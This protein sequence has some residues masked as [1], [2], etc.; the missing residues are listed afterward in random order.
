MS[1]NHKSQEALERRPAMWRQKEARRPLNLEDL[2]DTMRQTVQSSEGRRHKRRASRDYKLEG[3]ALTE[4]LGG[5]SMGGN[6]YTRE[7]SAWL[8]LDHAIAARSTRSMSE[9][10]DF[11]DYRYRGRSDDEGGEQENAFEGDL[12]SEED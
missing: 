2:F 4:M 7:D 12:P 3:R 8:D 6:R 1:K 11:D 5:E 10:L 9:E